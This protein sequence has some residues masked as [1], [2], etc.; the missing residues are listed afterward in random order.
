MLWTPGGETVL[1]NDYLLGE[2]DGR[3]P[4]AESWPTWLPRAHGS[5]MGHGERRGAG[6]S[7]GDGGV[8]DVLTGGAA[9][10]QGHWDRRV[11]DPVKRRW[12]VK[13][14][15]ENSYSPAQAGQLAAFMPGYGIGL[16][17]SYMTMSPTERRDFATDLMRE[18]PV[19]S[20]VAAADTSEGWEKAFHLGTAAIELPWLYGPGRG[21]GM[22]MRSAGRMAQNAP[23]HLPV[24]GVGGGGL[25]V[26]RPAKVAKNAF[27]D[28]LSEFHKRRPAQDFINDVQADFT[29]TRRRAHGYG[30]EFDDPGHFEELRAGEDLARIAREESAAYDAL[31]APE[32][33]RIRA[34]N[35]GRAG[36]WTWGPAGLL[37]PSQV[38]K[39][40]VSAPATAQGPDAAHLTTTMGPEDDAALLVNTKVT[41]TP[42]A[43]LTVNETA[44]EEAGADRLANVVKVSPHVDAAPKVKTTGEPSVN[45]FEEAAEAF[46]GRME[47]TTTTAPL[48]KTK[49]PAKAAP[50][51]DEVS[52]APSTKTKTAPAPTTAPM[53]V[54]APLEVT[55]SDGEPALQPLVFFSPAPSTVK[56]P[57]RTAAAVGAQ[58]VVFISSDPAPKTP[59]SAAAPKVKTTGEPSVNLFEE[60][61]EA[62]V[63][64]LRPEAI[65]A[66]PRVFLE[67]DFSK[68]VYE[69][70]AVEEVSPVVVTKTAPTAVPKAVTKIAPAWE[71]VIEL[72]KTPEQPE[73][74]TKVETVTEE[75]EIKVV[76]TETPFTPT[77]EEDGPTT[78]SGKNRRRPRGSSDDDQD[79]KAAKRRDRD[80]HPVVV[81]H[82]N[83]VR[84]AVN[85]ETGKEEIEIPGRRRDEDRPLLAEPRPQPNRPVGEP[86]DHNGQ[87]GARFGETA[88]APDETSPLLASRAVG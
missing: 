49:T 66:T 58:P 1:D 64:T 38:A 84:R 77:T 51:P 4:L 69:P 41:P 46:M 8:L 61:A 43:I 57:L 6:Q 2:S 21:A 86:D 12:P 75:P 50:L 18:T 79:E 48:T 16:E 62:F 35:A 37:V 22:A 25:G 14:A 32:L 23:K 13:D 56:A 73:A 45:L 67:E 65:P 24:Y 39:P 34:I 83:F 40:R 47:A 68:N 59:T 82:E 33:A 30:D 78:P 26:A 81:V 72:S 10:L 36:G 7:H 29:A 5:Y 3:R 80:A 9:W 17:P 76:V 74:V 60:A 27:D 70:I 55:A 44:I 88:E 54:A 31:V 19:L 53:E 71:P 28:F 20:G 63:Q 52:P 85:L 15:P 87:P 11:V 42:S